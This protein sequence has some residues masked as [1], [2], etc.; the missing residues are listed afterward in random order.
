MR[1]TLLLSSLFSKVWLHANPTY[2]RFS[3]SAYLFPRGELQTAKIGLT[4]IERETSVKGTPQLIYSYVSVPEKWP[5]WATFVRQ[6]TNEGSNKTHWVY[7]LGGMKVESVTEPTEVEQDR[8]YAFRQSSGF[9]KEG[10]FRLDIQPPVGSDESQIKLTFQYEPPYSYLG[11]L[12]DKLRI[13]EKAEKDVESSL[14]NLK[15]L[16]E[17]HSVS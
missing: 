4:T 6:A 3:L 1:I 10:R 5:Q 7:E 13:G 8:V 9:L 14:Q 12:V 2:S 15:R 11:K 17:T 16:V